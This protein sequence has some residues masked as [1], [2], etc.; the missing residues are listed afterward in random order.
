VFGE[1][2][3]SLFRLFKMIYLWARE[4]PIHEVLEFSAVERKRVG[5]MFSRLRQAIVSRTSEEPVRLGEHNIICQI[6][7]SLFSH[8]Q[9]NHMERVGPGKIFNFL[10]PF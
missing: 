5:E 1:S 6:D 9:K 2:R 7:E 4:V 8:K 10:P 3:I